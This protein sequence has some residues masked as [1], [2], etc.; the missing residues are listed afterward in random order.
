[1]TD[2]TR[3]RGSIPLIAARAWF[4]VLAAMTAAPVAWSEGTTAIVH[5]RL[6]TMT[7][8]EP[9]DDA[10]IVLRDG[11]VES[12]TSATSPPA[13]ARVVDARGRTV[14]PGLMTG[15]SQLGLIEVASLPDT[16][17]YSLAS[18]Q[19]G[20]AFDVQ[21]ALNPNSTL[22]Q[23]ALSDGLT[24]AV[25][26]P[27]GSAGAPFLGQGALLRLGSATGLL[28]RAQVAMFVRIGGGAAAG[29]GGSRSAAW[30]LLRNALEEARRYRPPTGV[31]GP[32]DQL[33]NRLDAEALRPV[34]AGRMLLAIVADR[35]S[36]I[37]QVIRLHDELDL[38]VV[39][40]GGA[41][42]W[43]VADDLARRG[44]PVAL[45]STLN[46]PASFDA[47]GARLDNAAILQRAGVRIAF[48][49]SAFHRTYNAGSGA[50][51]GA[52]LAVA[53]G[54]PWIEG[55]RALTVGPATIF[56]IEAHYGTVQKGR[57]ADLVIWDGDPLE[58]TTSA[59]Q[60][61]VR[62]V[63]ASLESRQSELARRYSPL[64]RHELPPA[65]R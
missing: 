20:A 40:Y 30:V 9:V 27:E 13:G 34:V 60:V 61:W 58:P 45:D 18:G 23:V 26:N 63:E 32:R 51:L 42:A 50:R 4:C 5:A 41:E 35:E 24:R 15:G 25:A 43:R 12:V 62:G 31:A 47:M 37:R 55:L 53:N 19:L 1:M 48:A 39:L 11:V 49:V 29:V 54:L 17:D 14:T 8:V 64:T 52:G 36:D 46:V 38:P 6:Y 28:E 59:V 7:S 3:S 33:L 65:Y 16:R 44:I 10:T 22:L 2:T 57:D 21:Y 56:G